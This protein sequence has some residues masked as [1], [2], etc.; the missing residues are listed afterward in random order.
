VRRR[1]ALR[2]LAN[3]G[4]EQPRRFGRCR[5]MLHIMTKCPET[6]ADVSTLHRMNQAEFDVFEGERS[7]RCPK[8]AR[9][10]TW[11]KRDAWPVQVSRALAARQVMDGV[12][13]TTV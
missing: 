10:H 8:C 6:G 9:V 5:Y 12:F 13:R 1:T 7:F 2:T 4:L 11:S 3:T